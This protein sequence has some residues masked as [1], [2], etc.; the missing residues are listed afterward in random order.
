[1]AREYHTMVKTRFGP[2]GPSCRCC[3]PHH[4][5]VS[6]RR[7]LRRKRRQ[8]TSM[9]VSRR[10][11]PRDFGPIEPIDDYELSYDWE[12]DWIFAPTGVTWRMLDKPFRLVPAWLRDDAED[13]YERER[14]VWALASEP[15]CWNWGVPI[16]LCDWFHRFVETLVQ[17]HTATLFAQ[18]G[19]IYVRHCHHGEP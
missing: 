6:A 9:F 2:G 5:R 11:E 13:D 4:T 15:I 8:Q 14:A 1:M 17:A 3:Q 12:D 19:T 16:S 7:A 10:P 18:W